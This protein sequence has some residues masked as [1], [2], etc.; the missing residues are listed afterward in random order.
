MGLNP[1]TP[2]KEAGRIIEPCVCSPIVK[3]TMPAATAAAEPLEL[4]PGVCSRFRGLR[5]GPGVRY[6][7]AVVTVLPSRIAPRPAHFPN[8]RGVRGAEAAFVKRRA[9]FGRHALRLDDVFGAKRNFGKRSVRRGPF[10][11]H[12]DPRVNGRLEFPDAL[13]A[14]LPIRVFE[15]HDPLAAIR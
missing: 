2:Q 4:P 11:L 8:D 13:Q 15:S 14:E 7:K 3:G 1:V 12:L 5:V 10:G 6:A 9:V